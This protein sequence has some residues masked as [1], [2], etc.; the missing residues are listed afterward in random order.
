MDRGFLDDDF[1]LSGDTARELFHGTAEQAPIVDVHN[2]LSSADIANNRVYDTLTDMWLEGDHYKWRAMRLA[3][4]DEQLVTGDRDPWE[5]FAAWA[6]T[7]PQLIRN[8]LYVWSH[9]ELRRVFGIDLL[10]SPAT[11]REIWEEA[12]RQLPRLST[13]ALTSRFDVRVIATTDDPGDDLVAHERFADRVEGPLVSMI[14]TL[15]PDLAHRLLDDPPTWNA[16]VDRLEAATETT[17]DDLDS[18]LEAISHSHRRFARLGGRSSDHG[19]ECLPDV[20]RDPRCADT[21]VRR[22]RSGGAATTGER[23]SVMLEVVARAARLAFESDAVL[24]LHL[25]AI[26]DVSPRLLAQ[27]G[28]DAGADVIGDVPQAAGLTRFLGSLERTA[29]CRAHS[30]T[31]PTPPTMPCSRA[32]QARFLGQAWAR[33]CNGGHPGGSTITSRECVGSSTTFHRS[34]NSR[35]SSAWSRTRALCSR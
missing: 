2:H 19:L 18:L 30:C 3:G 10:L 24:Q 4:I 6:A 8:P 22:V 20:S 15:R 29:H 14:P 5:K 25:G 16:W 12:N 13:Q 23:D 27:V 17:I 35:A 21:A 1:L 7:V 34:V 26:R 32:L 11:A 33:S 28:H 9:L 31:T